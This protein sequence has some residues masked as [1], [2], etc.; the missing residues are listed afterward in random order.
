M[1]KEMRPSMRAWIVCLSAALF[2]FYEFIQM[3][4]FNALS[5]PLMEAFKIDAAGL[6]EMSSYY[7]IA[8]VIF[9]IPA[10]ILL[11]RY[12]TR[13]IILIAFGICIVGTASFA[14]ATSVFW[15]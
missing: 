8:T 12:S 5:V 11:D 3:N 7:F 15:A 14:L 9:L 1:Y 6:G 10:G 13:K 2:F 4:M